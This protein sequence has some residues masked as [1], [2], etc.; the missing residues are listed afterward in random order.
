[1]E[2]IKII[3]LGFENCEAHTYK[4]A[5]IEKLIL[6]EVHKIESDFDENEYQVNEFYI[7][8]KPQANLSDNIDEN[9]RDWSKS[10]FNRISKFDDLYDITITYD[11]EVEE[12]YFLEWYYDGNPY[13][14]PYQKSLID[15]D[16]SL[17]ITVNKR[18][19]E[20]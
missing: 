18:N 5:D 15:V 8:L 3:E 1:M 7:K 6:R 12:K 10:P 4:G 17:H 19:K 9:F 11:N 13:S 16:G 14:N 20:E 2:N